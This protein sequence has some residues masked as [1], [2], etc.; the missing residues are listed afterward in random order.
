MDAYLKKAGLTRGNVYLMFLV[1]LKYLTCLVNLK[2]HLL[3]MFPQYLV[4]MF[5][6][7]Q[8]KALSFP[9]FP[10]YQRSHLMY[11]LYRM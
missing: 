10:Q 11:P 7:Y 6:K 5:L 3:K 8:K 1:L 2:C 4:L 9:M